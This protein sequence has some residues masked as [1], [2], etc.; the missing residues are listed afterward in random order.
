MLNL[1]SLKGYYSYSTDNKKKH[2]RDVHYRQTLELNLTRWRA[3]VEVQDDSC[4]HF[5]QKISTCSLLPQMSKRQWPGKNKLFLVARKN[6][7]RHR[8][9]FLRRPN[10]KSVIESLS[11][12]KGQV[13]NK[14]GSH[15]LVNQIIYLHT[16]FPVMNL[17]ENRRACHTDAGGGGSVC[18][19][20]SAS[21]IPD[22]MSLFARHSVE[23]SQSMQ[24]IL[25]RFFVWA[26]TYDLRR[27]LLLGP[28]QL[29]AKVTSSSSKLIIQDG[30]AWQNNSIVH[31]SLNTACMQNIE[32]LSVMVWHLLE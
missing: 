2:T 13:N 1:Y 21:V 5:A 6:R 11:E 3:T 9:P 19:P 17:V 24:L 30:A 28:N 32:T 12:D 4:L 22:E 14:N 23:S 10:D 27:A 31:V 16:T 15:A 8:V 25:G 29:S 20:A 18:R 7:P 26:V